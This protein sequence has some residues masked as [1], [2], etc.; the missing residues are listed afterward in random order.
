M[1]RLIPI[2]NNLINE[3]EKVKSKG[4]GCLGLFAC[5]KRPATVRC[6]IS[7]FSLLSPFNIHS[8]FLNTLAPTFK[9]TPLPH[10]NHSLTRSRKQL[11][12]KSGL[13]NFIFNYRPFAHHLELL[14][15][16]QRSWSLWS[17][18][19]ERPMPHQY[20]HPD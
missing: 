12:L 16:T 9:L 19:F 5:A 17:D 11:P 18:T 4:V 3:I 13:L 8:P 2:A 15:R 10:K 7:N 6:Q 1:T 20:T 14:L